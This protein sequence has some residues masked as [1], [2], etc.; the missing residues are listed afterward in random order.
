MLITG[1]AAQ[2]GDKRQFEFLILALAS[3]MIAAGVLLVIGFATRVVAVVGAMV[4][5]SSV[6]SWFPASTIGPV[7]TRMTAALSA[8]IALA[9]ICLGAG[10][11]SLDARLFGRREIIIPASPSNT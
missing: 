10:A 5:V 9:V 6:L 8:V 2:F 1:G 4:S 3:A 11:Y 7:E